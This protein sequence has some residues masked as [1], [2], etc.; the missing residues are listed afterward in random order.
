MTWAIATISFAMATL[1]ALTSS[2]VIGVWL[3]L[4]G[5]KERAR[6]P[7]AEARS[8]LLLGLLPALL[9]V[10]AMVAALSPSLGWVADHCV[11][12]PGHGHSHLCPRH[13]TATLSWALLLLAGYA[14]AQ[15][16]AQLW[17]LALSVRTVLQLRGALLRKGVA[18]ADGVVVLP[19][20]APQAFVLGAL[21]PTLFVS[22][23]LLCGPHRHHLGV[24][25]AHERAHIARHDGLRRV[26]ARLGFAF[27]LPV[28][29]VALEERLV[30]AQE[31][32]ADEDAARGVGSRTQ[33][34]EALVALARSKQSPAAALL[35]ADSDIEARVHSLLAPSLPETSPQAPTLLLVAAATFAAIVVNAEAVHHGLEIVV[36]WLGG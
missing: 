19:V 29:A 3:M 20:E 14:A 35:F 22:R 23:G 25:L 17:R 30:R 4:G 7:A 24:V 21:W 8:C 34:A 11:V 12:H 15:I 13:Q 28:V 18:T 1:V 6:T 27:H 2:A 32:A 5:G 10:A 26:I 36:S 9:G 31:M 33:V 16:G